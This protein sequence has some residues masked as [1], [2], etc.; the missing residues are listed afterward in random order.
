MKRLLRWALG[1]FLVLVLLAIAAVY[2][3]NPVARSIAQKRL[4]AQ[5]GMETQIGK[6]DFN[7]REQ[8]VRI[9][10]LKLI[11]P[12]EFGGSTFVHIPEL[13]VELNAEALRENRLHLKRVRIDLAEL[14]VVEDAEG[15]KN[16]DVFQKKAG[17]GQGG[18]GPG[19]DSP[20]NAPTEQLSFAGIDLL[21]IS[22]GQASFK[23]ERYPNRNYERNLGVRDRTFKEIKTEKDL[24]TV[25]VLLVAQI[26]MSALLENLFG[27]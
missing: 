13:Y 21:E 8:S 26:G 18:G 11:N 4:Q 12:P 16:T 2:S 6:F 25:G 5:T 3:I 10:D 9:S 15:R 14:H 19:G 17:T 22:L 7:F 27:K 24:E 1:I 20:T 23:S